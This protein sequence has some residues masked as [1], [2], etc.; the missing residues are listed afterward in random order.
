MVLHPSSLCPLLEWCENQNLF[1]HLFGV[2]FH[3]NV[4]TYVQPILPFEF[5]LCFNLS[6]NIQYRLSHADYKFALDASMPAVTLRWLFNTN[7]RNLGLLRAINT[8]IFPPNQGSAPAATIQT[9]LNAAV[10]TKMPSHLRWAHA[11]NNNADMVAIKHLVLN[12][13]LISNATLADVNYNYQM[14]L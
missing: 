4:H 6:D 9:L 11:Y 13:S 10:C 3:C 5:A 8:E 1:Q 7:K 12:P 14:P 2:E